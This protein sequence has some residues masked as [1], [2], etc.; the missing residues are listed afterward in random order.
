[1]KKVVIILCFL[2]SFLFSQNEYKN[3]VVVDYDREVEK[4]V[5]DS[6]KVISCLI[7]DSSGVEVVACE[8][9][10]IKNVIATRTQQTLGIGY[11]CIE[12]F[13]NQGVK[14]NEFMILGGIR[15]I[16]FDYQKG[17]IS[18]IQSF[19]LDYED[20]VNYGFKKNGI[21][22]KVSDRIIYEYYRNDEIVFR[23]NNSSEMIAFLSKDD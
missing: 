10:Y 8:E 15:K 18:K 22:V 3:D 4:I 19:E 23:S 5:N 1:M 11:F 21:T 7:K 20:K 13:D 6:I 14:I 16:R 2:P 9:I 12:N 17:K